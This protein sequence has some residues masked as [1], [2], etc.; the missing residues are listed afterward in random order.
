MRIISK[1]KKQFHPL[2]DNLSIAVYANVMM[3]I[4]FTSNLF[5]CTQSLYASNGIIAKAQ[6]SLGYVYEL[7]EIAL[8][9][10]EIS[11]MCCFVVIMILEMIINLLLCRLKCKKPFRNEKMHLYLYQEHLHESMC[12]ICQC[13]FSKLDYV[14]RLNCKCRATYH[15]HCL[16]EWYMREEECPLC[17]SHSVIM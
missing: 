6:C 15:Q 3:S 1:L 11:L 17:K 13:E 9:V 5:D 7:P 16:V 4:F 2:A 12:I 10:I 14:C 8:G